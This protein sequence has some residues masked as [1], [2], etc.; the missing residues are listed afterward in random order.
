MNNGAACLCVMLKAFSNLA[1]SFKEIVSFAMQRFH[2]KR[3]FSVALR[4]RLQ[5]L[6]PFLYASPWHWCRIYAAKQAGRHYKETF[7]KK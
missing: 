5:Y 1:A 7:A 4:L 6:S 2:S 3:M